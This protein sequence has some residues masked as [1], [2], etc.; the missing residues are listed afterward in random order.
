[1]SGSGTP[2]AAHPYGA[3]AAVYDELAA[4]YSLGAIDR[5]KR[6]GVSALAPGERVLFVG[7]GRGSDVVGAVRRGCRVTAVDLAPAML[8]RLRASLD[9]EGLAAETILGDVADH[10]PA[11]PYDALVA[12][13]FL[14]L[15]DTPLAGAMLAH[16]R[17]LV[18][19]GGRLVVADF[20]RPSGGSVASLLANAYYRPI[21]WLAWALG[22]CAL[23]PILDYGVLLPAAGFRITREQRFAVLGIRDPA[24]V[25]IVAQRID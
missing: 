14:N 5:S 11:E 12:H 8:A 17:S 7:A 24:Y 1:M 19:P 6:A 4:L 20:A 16:L 10:R 25:S 9:R 22:Y 23:H 21:D 13:Y 15:W 3:V 2:F 18:R